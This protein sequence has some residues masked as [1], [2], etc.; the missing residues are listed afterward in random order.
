M[1]SRFGALAPFRLASL[2]RSRSR[3][4]RRGSSV[5]Y[6]ERLA[7]LASGFAIRAAAVGHR[8]AALS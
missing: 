7:R 5:A 6:I 3:D 8:D 4:D 2:D 1:A